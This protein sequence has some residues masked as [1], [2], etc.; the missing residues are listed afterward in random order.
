VLSAAAS[1]AAPSLDAPR[2]A[3]VDPLFAGGRINARYREVPSN[4]KVGLFLDYAAATSVFRDVLI[5]TPSP[6]AVSRLQE[7]PADQ[8]CA[9]GFAGDMLRQL[10]DGMALDE[11]IECVRGTVSQAVWDADAAEWTVTIR[12]APADGDEAPGAVV[13]THSAPMLVYCT[14]A[15]PKSVALLPAAEPEPLD[16][17]VA[18]TP[19]VLAR[20]IPADRPVTIG[21]VGASHS[22]VL[23]LMNLVALARSSHPA[24][25]VRWFSRHPALRFAEYKDGWILYDNTGL[26]GDAAKWARAH[27]DGDNLAKSTVAG[28]VI[29]RVDC[30]GGADAERAAFAE[31]LP[32]CDS[33]VQAVGY[34]NAPLPEMPATGPVKYDHETGG[35][36]EVASGE[37]VR[38]LFGA[39][40]AFPERV[41]DRAGNVEHAVGFWKFMRFLK[42]AVPEWVARTA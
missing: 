38:G 7:L 15:A 32:A 24:L 39:G 36:M 17:D 29:T 26:K 42:R 14:G 30:S 22:A 6:N 13:D 20:T 28:P 37:P 25:R 9:L 5:Q 40:I 12:E 2:V 21:V 19:S 41:V 4:T 33:V 35:F 16:L 1:P 3:W 11:R 23:V 31:H 10:S 8:T 27:L 34:Q 18:L